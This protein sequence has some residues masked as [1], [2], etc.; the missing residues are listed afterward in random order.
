MNGN[1]WTAGASGERERD[2]GGGCS[3]GAVQLTSDVSQ[4]SVCLLLCPGIEYVAQFHG[5]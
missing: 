1:R 4:G 5:R 2:G 3:G